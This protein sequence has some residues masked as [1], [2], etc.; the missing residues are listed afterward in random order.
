MN[1]ECHNKPNATQGQ[2]IP[3]PN[4]FKAAKAAATTTTTAST[5]F[6]T[7]TST[8]TDTSAPSSGDSSSG[9][10]QGAKA[11]IGVGCAVGGLFLIGI[12]WLLF[13]RR[14]KGNDT[15]SEETIVAEENMV[16]IGSQA[17]ELSADSGKFEIGGTEVAELP[18]HND[19]R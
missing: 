8:G 14:Q 3:A 13:R 6:P 10:S 18:A 2:T 16:S 1:T 7:A 12:I 5:S 17:E 11:G 4:L 19:P 9:L 15:G